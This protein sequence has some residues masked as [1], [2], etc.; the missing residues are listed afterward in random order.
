MRISSDSARRRNRER[1][2]CTSASGPWR[3]GRRMLGEPPLRFGFRDNCEDLDCFARDVIEDPHLSNPEAILRLA[4]APQF[5]PALAPPG[6]LMAQVPLEG[7]PYLCSTVGRTRSEGAN[8]LGGEDTPLSHSA[9]I[10]ATS[11]YPV[12]SASGAPPAPRP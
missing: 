6:G 9:S 5:D 8:R 11:H 4:Q 3:T 10:I 7:V 12:K 1:S 2:S